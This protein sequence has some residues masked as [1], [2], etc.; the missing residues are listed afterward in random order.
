MSCLSWYQVEKQT[1]VYHSGQRAPR[2]AQPFFGERRRTLEPDTEMRDQAADD[3][4]GSSRL[5]IV[6]TGCSPSCRPL[7]EPMAEELVAG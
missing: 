2:T 7:G 3:P 1:R 4:C 6:E 5:V